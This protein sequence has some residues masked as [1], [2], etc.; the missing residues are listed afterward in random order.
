[1]F[2]WIVL[3]IM[4]ICVVVVGML[5]SYLIRAIAIQ[6]G[7]YGKLPLRIGQCEVCKE[8]EIKLNTGTIMHDIYWILPILATLLYAFV[9]PFFV[10]D[11]SFSEYLR[12]DAL[13]HVVALYVLLVILRNGVYAALIGDGTYHCT[14]CGQGYFYHYDTETV[15]KAERQ[16]KA[17]S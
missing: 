1:M 15:T 9:A 13:G 16:V 5:P 8:G 3:L 10:T 11:V 12:S 4:G 14:S 17:P 7:R 2:S 6:L